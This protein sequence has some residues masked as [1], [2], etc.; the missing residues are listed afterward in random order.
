MSYSKNI[1]SIIV[2]FYNE[3]ASLEESILNL[4]SQE[5]KKE[6]IL[7]NDGSTDGSK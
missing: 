2:P 1:T 3:E 5:F 7:I 4:V 6:I